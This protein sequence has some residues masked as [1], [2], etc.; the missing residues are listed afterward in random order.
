MC[1]K[2]GIVLPNG[3]KIYPVVLDCSLGVDGYGPPGLFGTMKNDEIDRRFSTTVL[4]SITCEPTVGNF[5]ASVFSPEGWAMTDYGFPLPKKFC[6]TGL[7]NNSTVNSFGLTNDGF[8]DFLTLNF[9]E[10]NIIPSIFFKFE[11]GS[12]KDLK[13]VKSEAIYM[14]AKLKSLFPKNSRKKID[15]VVINISCPNDGNGVCSFND[16]IV[17]VI[18]IF[19][20]NIGDIPVGIKYSYMQDVSMAVSIDNE[21]DIAFHQAINTIPFKEVFGNEKYS[22]LSHIGHGGVSGPAIKGMAL[23]YL[24]KLREALP[25][26]KIIGGGGISSLK[27]AIERSRYCDAIAIGILV[28]KDPKLANEII[29]YFS[30]GGK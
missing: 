8:D 27:D 1:K 4:K 22:P 5:G 20:E 12:D 7:E 9:K 16:E 6:Y 25:N 26:A 29:K 14:A 15:A 10:D 28:N 30:E 18:K 13:R 24:I 2:I 3:S 11:K 19:K 21:V 17:K 23:E